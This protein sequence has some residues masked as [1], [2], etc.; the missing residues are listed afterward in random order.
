MESTLAE[1]AKRDPE[2]WGRDP[3][4]APTMPGRATLVFDKPGRVL[5][6]PESWVCYRAYYLRLAQ[7]ITSVI[8]CCSRSTMG[9]YAKRQAES[10]T[11][12]MYRTALVEERPN[13]RANRKKGSVRIWIETWSAPSLDVVVAA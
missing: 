7:R 13:N 9:D 2:E 5:G 10:S 12:Q 8:A 6:P 11:A 1:I 4:R 3:W